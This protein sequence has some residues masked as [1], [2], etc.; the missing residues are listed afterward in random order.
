LL[1]GGYIKKI[2]DINV[3]DVTFS[4][5]FGSP[6]EIKHTFM[7]PFK[8]KLT[9]LTFYG[10]PSTPLVCT[11]DHRILGK[12][13]DEGWVEAKDAQWI[14]S[15]I[16]EVKTKIK[17]LPYFV[18]KPGKDIHEKGGEIPLDYN[19]GWLLGLYYA[20]GSQNSGSLTFSLSPK[21]VGF[22][23]KIKTF[24]D[25]YNWGISTTLQDTNSFIAGRQIKGKVMVVRVHSTSLRNVVK[26]II[27]DD[28]E[29]PDWLWQCPKQF[30]EG[31]ID[32]YVDGDGHWDKKQKRFCVTSVR[33]QLLYQIRELLLSTRQQYAGIGYSPKRKG[34]W[35]IYPMQPCKA[36]GFYKDGSFK[37]VKFQKVHGHPFVFVKVRK[38][39]ELDYDGFVYDIETRGSFKTPSGIVHNSEVAKYPPRKARDLFTDI[40]QTVPENGYLTMESTPKGRV[41][42]FYEIYQAAKRGEVNYKAFFYPWWWDITCVRP[43]KEPLEYTQEEKDLIRRV[44]LEEDIDLSP[45]QIAFRR[46]KI[47][48]LRELFFQE[49]PEN[50]KDCW[51]A[52]EMGVFDGAIIRKYVN[53]VLPGEVEGNL[54]TWKGVIGGEKYIIGV[55]PA[56]GHPKGDYSVASVLRLKTNE[57]VARLRGR[58]PVDL[59][60]EELYRLGKKYNY[61]TLVIPDDAYG[62]MILQLMQAKNYPNI[63]THEEYNSLTGSV[64][65]VQGYRV[66]VNTK[67]QM[68][69]TLAAA[70]RSND[71]ISWSDNLMVEASGYVYEKSPSGRLKTNKAGG[72]F[73]DELDAVMIA[74]QARQEIPVN[75]FIDTKRCDPI[76]YARI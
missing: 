45:E 14:G 72:G 69:S 40:S 41:G 6:V 35:L 30:L 48:E 71:L 16:R 32:G 5:K 12:S 74:L 56:G 38:K 4:K 43:V 54:T 52:S 33:P 13:R 37:Y 10:N 20:E 1:A 46:E 53:Q 19:F 31:V 57:Y 18:Y 76:S 73:D 70:L 63:F 17:K 62:R 75:D 34:W 2:S 11:P 28:K 29:M 65:F 22:R 23:D 59:F 25:K 44:K 26:K 47:A 3:G 15:P 50:D 39:E 7:R 42:I 66:N 64:T 36:N 51:L 55:D 8:G 67:P 49:Y 58:I 68:V 21:E 24:C 60:G 9:K 27:G 61:A